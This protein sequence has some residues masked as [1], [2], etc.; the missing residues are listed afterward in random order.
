MLWVRIKEVNIAS[1]F[2]IAFINFNNQ[3][4]V[5]SMKQLGH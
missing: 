1:F 3:S 2:I 5:I 4:P